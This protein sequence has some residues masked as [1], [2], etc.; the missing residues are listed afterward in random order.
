MDTIFYSELFIILMF[1]WVI[2]YLLAYVHSTSL[3]IIH[4][5]SCY[6]FIFNLGLKVILVA[7]NYQIEFFNSFRIFLS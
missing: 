4:S 5:T 6:N 3:Y 1:T 2:I 7:P